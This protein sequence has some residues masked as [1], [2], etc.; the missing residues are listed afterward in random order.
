MLREV[1]IHLGDIILD[2]TG[3]YSPATPD[4]WY[5]PNGDPGY[6]GE[7]EE[8]EIS[9]VAYMGTDI[10]SVIEAMNGILCSTVRSQFNTYPNEDVWIRIENECL[11]ELIKD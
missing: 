1:T 7:S 9:S 2:V 5:L 8:F 4:V 10:T 6:P 11:K 3:D